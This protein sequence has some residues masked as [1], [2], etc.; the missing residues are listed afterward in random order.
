MIPALLA[1]CNGQ[2]AQE[3]AKNSRTYDEAPA[4]FAATRGFDVLTG[5]LDQASSSTATFLTR[6]GSTW[7]PG[8]M[9]VETVTFFR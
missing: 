9:V 1:R 5:C 8:P 3:K 2:E 4:T 7:T 6:L